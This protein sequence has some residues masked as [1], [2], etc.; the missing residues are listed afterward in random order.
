[1]EDD[2]IERQVLLFLLCFLLY[3]SLDNR[4]ARQFFLTLL[5]LLLLF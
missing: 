4:G 3:C 5:L 1:M 2:G